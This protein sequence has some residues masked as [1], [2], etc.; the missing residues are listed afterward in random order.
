MHG[1][2]TRN[3]GPSKP[4]GRV[5]CC[6]GRRCSLETGSAGSAESPRGILLRIE[7]A[8]VNCN[9]PIWGGKTLGNRLVEAAPLTPVNVTVQSDRRSEMVANVHSSV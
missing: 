1:C 4:R 2:G 6:G 3:H 8:S 7:V 5:F 9:S